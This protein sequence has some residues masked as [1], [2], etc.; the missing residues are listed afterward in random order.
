MSDN[1]SIV[2]THQNLKFSFCETADQDTKKNSISDPQV[3]ASFGEILSQQEL[4]DSSKAQVL[5]KELTVTEGSDNVATLP[6]ENSMR[7]I[8]KVS[9][10][11][12]FTIDLS[13][14][15]LHN[16]STSNTQLEYE[17]MNPTEVPTQLEEVDLDGLLNNYDNF[18]PEDQEVVRSM[19]KQKI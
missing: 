6:T 2:P 19:L 17:Q 8:P 7:G 9:N 12:N 13:Q 18:T 3:P 1:S 15:F 16:Q 10:S 4:G 5:T 14:H 11:N